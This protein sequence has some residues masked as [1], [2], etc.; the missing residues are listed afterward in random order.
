MK[1]EVGQVVGAGA[2]E[3]SLREVLTTSE[4]P[5]F[6][7]RPYQVAPPPAPFN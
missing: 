4:V 2:G 5:P 7:S 6:Q 3:A 1:G